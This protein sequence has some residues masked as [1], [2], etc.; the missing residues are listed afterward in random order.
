MHHGVGGSTVKRVS[1]DVAA[2]GIDPIELIA[3]LLPTR[4]RRLAEA[5]A[6]VHQQELL[7]D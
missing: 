1:G 4:Q 6:E 5:W 7:D 3:G 2:I